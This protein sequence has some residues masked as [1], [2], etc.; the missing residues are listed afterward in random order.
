MPATARSPPPRA[1]G[2]RAHPLLARLLDPKLQER[3][4]TKIIERY[5][6]F[7]SDAGDKDVLLSRFAS[8]SL[9]APQQQQQQQHD[10]PTPPPPSPALVDKAA[11]AEAASL[12]PASI[13][14]KDLSD[15]LMALRKLREGL[16]ASKRADDFAAQAY[17]FCARLAILARR[18]EAYHPAL[19]HLLRFLH[20]RH[21]L[22]TLEAAEVAGYLVLDAACRRGQVAEALLLKRRFALRDARVDAV[23]RALVADNWVAFRRLM[24]AV[25]AHRRRLMEY[26]EPDMRLHTLKCFGRT[27]LSVDVDFLERSTGKSFA[28]LQKD[29]GVGWEL[30]G[31]RVVVRKIKGKAS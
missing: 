7:C 18:P 29:Q 16:V 30:D 21:P 9:S 26:A 1:P 4:Y 17:L 22:T 15:V 13:P 27:Y 12:P 3:Y 14:S 8:L 31:R 20:P 11:A 6:S 2:P 24:G 5:L 10:G 19:L 23:L 28:D 25:D